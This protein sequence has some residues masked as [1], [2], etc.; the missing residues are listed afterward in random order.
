MMFLTAFGM[1][2][3]T[4]RDFDSTYKQKGKTNG[5][6]VFTLHTYRETFVMSYLVQWAALCSSQHG[7]FGRCGSKLLPCRCRMFL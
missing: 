7:L 4:S 3:R 1:T 5:I 6:C 2:H